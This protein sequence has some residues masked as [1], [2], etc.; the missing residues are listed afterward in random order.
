MSVAWP[1][2]AVEAKVV[3]PW[4]PFD[5]PTISGEYLGHECPSYRNRILVLLPKTVPSSLRRD[6][7][8]ATSH[9]NDA[10]YRDFRS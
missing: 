2:N 5:N 10:I 6:D 4:R 3:V 1:G 9:Y 8:M 7:N